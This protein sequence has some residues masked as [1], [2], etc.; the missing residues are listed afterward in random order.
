M[1]GRERRG[2]Y[3]QHH[4]ARRDEK[5]ERI[6]RQRKERKRDRGIERKGEKVNL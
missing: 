5:E 3:R 6:E 1:K 2:I 4:E